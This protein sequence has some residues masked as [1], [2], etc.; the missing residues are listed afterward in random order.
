MFT[1]QFVPGPGFERVVVGLAAAAAGQPARL[2]TMAADTSVAAT[3]ALQAAAPYDAEA[4]D[5]HLRDSFVTDMAGGNPTV[6]TISNTAPQHDYVIY[7]HGDIYP[8]NA[9]A[10]H[11]FTHG[12]EVFTT[13][14]GPVDP[15]DYPARA[16]DALIPRLVAIATEDAALIIAELLGA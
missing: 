15:N 12:A 10:L 9:K 4:P 14:V 16:L 6:V 13:H 7:G 11:F 1:L 8:V 5:P 3:T 2:A